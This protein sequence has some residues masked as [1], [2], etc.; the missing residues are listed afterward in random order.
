[1]M[2]YHYY[3]YISLFQANRAEL[4]PQQLQRVQYEGAECVIDR[5]LARDDAQKLFQAGEKKLGT[6]ES[7]FLQVMAVRHYYQLRATFEE[8]VR[9][10]IVFLYM[11]LSLTGGTALCPLV[12]CFI[13]CLILVQPIKTCPELTEKVFTWM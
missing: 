10:M 8:Y 4:T 11:V 12:R 3:S 9:V 1:M 7:V 5:N 2:I 13:L 6:D